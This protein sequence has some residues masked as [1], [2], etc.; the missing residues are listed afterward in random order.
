MKKSPKFLKG[1]AGL[2]YHRDVWDLGL[3]VDIKNSCLF[4]WGNLVVR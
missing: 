4:T 3:R 2:I 1:D